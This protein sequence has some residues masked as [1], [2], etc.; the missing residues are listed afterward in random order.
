MAD[1]LVPV[2]VSER[3]FVFYKMHPPVSNFVF[4]KVFRIQTLK[5]VF[6]DCG[7]DAAA[8]RGKHTENCS[9]RS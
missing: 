1:D 7:S 3:H 4:I 8:D 2:V 9:T 6:T 5:S